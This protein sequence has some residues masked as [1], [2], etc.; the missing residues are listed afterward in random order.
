MAIATHARAIAALHAAVVLFG[1]AGLFGKWVMLS[2][3]LIVLGR[4]FVAALALALFSLNRTRRIGRPDL[5]MIASGAVLALHWVT[6]FAAIQTASVAVGLLGYAA[7]PVFTLLLERLFLRRPLR[8]AD[9]GTAALVVGGLVLVV[10]SWTLNSATVQG[11]GWGLVSAF[12]FALLAVLNRGAAGRRSASD[13]ALWQNAAAALCL[14]PFAGAALA[15]AAP[16]PRD[17]ILLIVLGVVCTAVA[18]TLFIASLRDVTAHVASVVA[19]LEPV[20]G[21]ALAWALLAEVP[22]GRMWGGAA[23]LVTAAVVASRAPASP[24]LAVAAPGH[25]RGRVPP[26]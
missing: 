24:V 20:Y 21:I 7:F 22:T 9:A 5:R 17:V 26:T 25:V 12:T 18:H 4:T 19:A 2:P 10:P 14:L 3:V 23:L 8:G 16:G 1:F 6:F 13:I 15:T 11:L